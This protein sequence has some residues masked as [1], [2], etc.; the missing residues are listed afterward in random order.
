MSKNST[1]ENLKF[2]QKITE[3][4]ILPFTKLLRS[5]VGIP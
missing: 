5:L 2:F 3:G 1:H 4:Q